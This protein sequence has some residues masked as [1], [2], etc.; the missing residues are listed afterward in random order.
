MKESFESDV[1]VGLLQSP[2]TM[3]KAVGTTYA[4][5]YISEADRMVILESIQTIIVETVQSE[6]IDAQLG[7]YGAKAGSV[8]VTVVDLTVPKIDSQTMTDARINGDI[9]EGE[10]RTSLGLPAKKPPDE[11]PVNDDTGGTDGE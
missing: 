9:T 10:Y 5:G 11:S 8:I 6:I 2:L 3:G 1:Q 4:S 7:A